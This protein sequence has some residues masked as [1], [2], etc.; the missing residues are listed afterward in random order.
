MWSKLTST[1]V[2]VLVYHG[3]KYCDDWKIRQDRNGKRG[4]PKISIGSEWIGTGSL[5][6]DPSF[7][8]K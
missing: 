2:Y 5:A 3:G 1:R 6:G 8:A 7:I 4:I